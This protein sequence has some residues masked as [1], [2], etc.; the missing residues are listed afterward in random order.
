MKQIISLK[1]IL[2]VILAAGLTALTV[3]YAEAAI[4][5]EIN[6]MQV[7]QV[8]YIDENTRLVLARAGLSV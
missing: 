8:H 4:S 2:L 3:A 5:S 1:S 6:S 7:N